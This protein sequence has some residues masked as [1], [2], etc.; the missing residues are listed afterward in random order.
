MPALRR[1]GVLTPPASKGSSP[2]RHLKLETNGLDY[3]VN[4][5]PAAADAGQG[6]AAGERLTPQMY[7][8]TLV[9]V[10]HNLLSS[11]SL[12]CWFMGIIPTYTALMGE[13]GLFISKW[14]SEILFN[15]FR[16]NSWD[17]WFHHLS[18]MFGVAMSLG[19]DFKYATPLLMMNSIHIP[20]LLRWIKRLVKKDS[21]SYKVATNCDLLIWP[22]IACARAYIMLGYVYNEPTHMPVGKAIGCIFPLLDLKWTPWGG[23]AKLFATLQSQKS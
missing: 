19:L 17:L 8:F 6:I 20:L 1:A 5:Q 2:T 4:V 12:C 23:Y 21:I 18:Y 22:L 3:D 15:D 13:T 7:R 9:I 10:F 16:W 14:I 11:I